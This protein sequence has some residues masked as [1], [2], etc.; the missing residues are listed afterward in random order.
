M[1]TRN[2]P[3]DLGHYLEA[4]FVFNYFCREGLFGLSPE[5]ELP[6]SRLSDF[7]SNL[8]AS[9]EEMKAQ[10]RALTKNDFRQGLGHLYS[11]LPQ[12]IS[13]SSLLG[14]Q[15]SSDPAVYAREN[16]ML[17]KLSL[18]ILHDPSRITTYLMSSQNEHVIRVS[19]QK[20]DLH[21]MELYHA[22]LSAT[23]DPS[24]AQW[25]HVHESMRTSAL[26]LKIRNVSYLPNISPYPLEFCPRFVQ[27]S[28][29][30][31]QEISVRAE[32][33]HFFSVPFDF[34]LE[35]HRHEAVCNI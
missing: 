14:Y 13:M 31:L 2:H 30:D 17:E 6:L 9:Y 28:G 11:L 16:E 15:Q 23:T 22:V 20:P 5:K 27:E 24:Q 34:F 29:F 26:P 35:D 32:W 8:F 4:I 1:N 12:I 18:L 3:N 25:N 7:S 21:K 10:L 19:G 33:E